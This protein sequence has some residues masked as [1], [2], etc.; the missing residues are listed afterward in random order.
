MGKVGK[1]HRIED[2]RA[3]WE[4]LTPITVFPDDVIDQIAGQ[5]PMQIDPAGRDLLTRG[6]RFAAQQQI[7][8]GRYPRPDD[9]EER[10]TVSKDLARVSNQAASLHKTLEG[11]IRP[12]SRGW[13]ELI[14]NDTPQLN[15]STDLK[16]LLKLLSCLQDR[17]DACRTKLNAPSRRGPRRTIS[18]QVFVGYLVQLYMEIAKRRP[19]RGPSGPFLRFATSAWK[20]VFGSPAG[21]SDVFRTCRGNHSEA[22]LRINLIAV[23]RDDSRAGVYDA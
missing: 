1:R 17:A 10:R 7:L 8:A 6:L 12:G 4:Q 23:L 9:R 15:T 19:G 3:H 18:R 2:D 20:C 22:L 14:S 16:E 21:L 11:A 5:L 13:Y